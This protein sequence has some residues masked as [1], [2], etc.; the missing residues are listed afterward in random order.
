MRPDHI[1]LILSRDFAEPPEEIV[2]HYTKQVYGGSFTQSVRECFGGIVRTAMRDF[3]N[4][5]ID[6]RLMVARDLEEHPIEVEV[7]EASVEASADGVVTTD[8]ERDAYLIVKAIVRDVVAH[9]RV[10]IRDGKTYCSV[11]LDNNNRRPLCRLWFNGKT[12]KYLG[13]FDGSRKETKVLL[14]GGVDAI[15]Q[16]AKA[17]RGTAASYA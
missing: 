2:R 16:H 9:E 4:D 15:F 11:L 3:V 7:A 13:L 8:E 6:T 17:L 10:T 1:H 5:R 14:E 12:R